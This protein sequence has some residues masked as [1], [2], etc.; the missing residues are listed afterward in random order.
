M[1]LPA[2]VLGKSSVSSTTVTANSNNL[3]SRSYFAFLGAT[4]SEFASLTRNSGPFH[5]AFDVRCSVFAVFLF[6]FMRM[7]SARRRTLAS[8]R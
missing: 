8:K 7:T 6:I 4:Y 1:W 2:L 3:F 5:S